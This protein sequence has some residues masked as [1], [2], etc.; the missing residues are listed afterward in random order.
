MAQPQFPSLTSIGPPPPRPLPGRGVDLGFQGGSAKC[1]DATRVVQAGGLL[2]NLIMHPSVRPWQY[3]YR[4]NPTAGLYTASRNRPFQLEVG[5]F[6]VPQNQAL[7]VAEYRFT[8]FTFSGG[9]LD[10]VPIEPDS[11]GLA[12]AYAFNISQ[13]NPGNIRTEIVPATRPPQQAAFLGLPTGGTM[14]LPSQVQGVTPDSSNLAFSTPYGLGSV[15]QST[16]PDTAPGLSFFQ[17][18]AKQFVTSVSGGDGLLVQSQKGQQGPSKFPFTYYA[19]ATQPV[20]MNVVAFKPV[21]VAI[22]YFEVV[23]M[24]YLLAAEALEAMLEGVRPCT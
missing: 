24:G 6:T 10:T 16:T 17:D 3:T 7:A 2:A 11:Q 1:M 12:I 19:K 14:S 23:V 4:A 9:M 5:A 8:P 22:A 20:Q 21:T 18:N 15:I 13:Q